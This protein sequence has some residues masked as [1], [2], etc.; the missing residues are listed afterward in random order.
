MENNSFTEIAEKLKEAESVLI[1]THILMDGDAI[2][3]SGALCEALRGAG[4]EAHVLIEDKIPDN[5]EFLDRGYCTYDQD[6]IKDPDICICLDVGDTGRFPERAG[7]FSTGGLKICID[8][9]MTSDPFCDLN[10][11]DPAAAATSELM[12]L[13]LKEGGFEITKPVAE[14]IFAGITTDTGNFQYSN[15]TKRCHEIA[16][17]LYDRGL[18]SNKISIQIYENEKPQKLHLKSK[19]FGAVE[20]LAGGQLAVS[21][22]SQEM[23]RETGCTMEDSEGIIDDL[24]AVRG[25]QIAIIM[26]E[27]APRKIKAT[28]RSKEKGD[29]SRIASIHGGGGHV[30]AAGCTIEDTLENALKVIK[31]DALSE[32]GYE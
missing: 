5:L 3:S 1:F 18:D 12:Y 19:I 22:V 24:R 27:N 20:F 32:L 30:R 29:V 13:M 7:K 4:K 15:T 25:V 16:A 2:G 26:K 23:L 11:I 21:Y 14:S 6:I 8:H 10:Y 9:H 31:E 28:M 17:E